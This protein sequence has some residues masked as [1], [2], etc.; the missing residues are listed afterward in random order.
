MQFKTLI[1][2]FVFFQFLNDCTAQ[3]TDRTLLWRI[4]GKGLQKPSYLYG[5]MHLT[6]DRLFNLGDSLY[7]AIEKTEGFAIEID[8]QEFSK[9]LANE[10]Y[11]VATQSQSLTKVI[12]KE[13]LKK[14]A[15]QLSKKFNK[16]LE[17]ITVRDI[18]AE[19][20]K[21]ISEAYQ[22][23]KMNT[24]L[25]AYL[26]D[27][28]RKQG[29]WVGGVEDYE[30][31][32]GLE[33]VIDKTDIAYITASS[34]GKGERSL[35]DLMVAFYNSGDLDGIDSLT[36]RMEDN[37]R[38][39]L[40]LKRNIKMA[41]RM[42]SLSALQSMVFAVGAAHLPGEGGVIDLLKKKGFVVEPVFSSKK[43]K[44]ADY[45][46]K[47][48]PLIWPV[49]KDENDLYEV[50]MPGQ[51]ASVAIYGVVN[52]KVYMDIF[53]STAYFST[54]VTGTWDRVNTD[55]L[56]DNMAAGFSSS[57][58]I[59][60]GK[61]VLL[62]NMQGRQYLFP[63][64]DGYKSI[65]LFLRNT[66]VYALVAVSMKK[67]IVS[68]KDTDKFFSSLK[69]RQRE[70]NSTHA[71]LFTDS[72]GRF[73]LKFPSKPALVPTASATTG[74]VK[75]STYAAVDES[76]GLYFM[77]VTAEATPGNYILNDSVIISNIRKNIFEKTENITV[78]TLLEN[79]GFK[80]MLLSGTYSANGLRFTAKYHF[81]GNRWHTILAIGNEKSI[82]HASVNDFLSSFKLSDVETAVWNTRQDAAK[83]F[84][85]WMPNDIVDVND[86]EAVTEL[87]KSHVASFDAKNAN[88]YDVMLIKSNPFFW[89][90]SDSSYWKKI[91][92]SYIDKTNSTTV[93]K[94]VSNE[95]YNGW[96]M[97][98]NVSGTNMYHRIRFLHHGDDLYILFSSLDKTRINDENTNKFFSEFKFLKPATP[99]TYLVNKTEKLLE[100]LSSSDSATQNYAISFLLL[101]PFTKTDLPLLHAALLKK[102]E[103]SEEWRDINDLI[104]D[105]IV[106]VGDTSTIEFAKQHIDSP[107]E[108]K[109]MLQL[110]TDFKTKGSYEVLANIFSQTNPT[111]EL[112][113]RWLASVS[114]SLLLT[115]TIF[116]S[117]LNL[118]K[119]TLSASAISHIANMLVDSNYIQIASVKPF[120]KAIIDQALF[121]ESNNKMKD[122]RLSYWDL[123]VLNLLGKIGTPTVFSTL[124]KFHDSK[125][126]DYA[127][128]SIVESLKGS[129]A[130]S[131]SSIF[132]LAADKSYRSTFY[133]KLAEI[134]KTALFPL[135]YATPKMI[136]E[137]LLQNYAADDNEVEGIT[138]FTEKIKSIKSKQAAYYFYKLI[139]L[140]EDDEEEVY[141]GVV[142]SLEKKNGKFDL[143]KA[144]MLIHWDDVLTKEN[145]SKLISLL[146]DKLNESE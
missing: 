128:E 43:L 109:L 14:Y 131:T 41:R 89:A 29:K 13:E 54:A 127:M 101:A 20:N 27:I 132:R 68:V 38:D 98:Q 61:P 76:T 57:K 80:E 6:D 108:R 70:N 113:Y 31:Q 35:I 39:I 52:M 138:Y 107:A 1:L 104:K 51:A 82:Q 141:L 81:L 69:I 110:L 3:K 96:E 5:T 91:T 103:P 102:Y 106:K 53:N 125:S 121:L 142:T 95:S 63:D 97:I 129:Q 86:S 100:G 126:F 64:A 75:T 2:S 62:N 117:A 45:K 22:N 99:S 72:L 71:F 83:T 115:K 11:N 79:N 15:P 123:S 130:V 74:G 32:A 73:E 92:A 34:S 58:K 47:E 143:D 93:N 77:L 120:E 24:M 78:D 84:S 8:P 49:V 144:D 118:L 23:G 133:Q 139:L 16:P 30:D 9:L 88:S 124:K 12:S 136:G 46:F 105:Q 116:P 90:T 48:V 28:A 140:N 7:S 60:K 94:A 42:D 134:N 135:L 65:Q 146:I 122:D 37:K 66:T 67:N 137:S 40:L 50:Q 87:L 19:K 33:E 56:L 119:D 17:E 112:G 25:D 55:S 145:E 18:V 114:D 26:F 85:A 21:W 111:A 4:S 59:L 44:P 36:N 10:I